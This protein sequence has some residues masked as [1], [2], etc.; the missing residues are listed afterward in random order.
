MLRRCAT[1]TCRCHCRKVMSDQACRSGNGAVSATRAPGLKLL[2]VMTT[3]SR[4]LT[5]LWYSLQFPHLINH[6]LQTVEASQD[7]TTSARALIIVKA[8]FLSTSPGNIL[9]RLL[10]AIQFV[11]RAMHNSKPSII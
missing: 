7:L 9:L 2:P 4:P 5:W 8:V 11:M 1:S 10:P 3:P 6:D